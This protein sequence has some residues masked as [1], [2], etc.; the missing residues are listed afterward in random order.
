MDARRTGRVYRPLIAVLVMGL[1][2]AAC[3]GGG[4]SGGDKNR[5]IYAGLNDP[6]D[7]TIAV[8]SFLPSVATVEVGASVRWAFLGPEPHTVTFVP[9]G[10][11][12]PLPSD[13]DARAVV[14]AN[15]P[16]D[17]T[18]KVSSGL[19]GASKP[20]Q[21]KITFGKTGKF[22]YYCSIHPRM[23]ATLNVVAAGQKSD[24]KKDLVTR[25]KSERD[26]YLAEGRAGKKTYSSTQPK[27]TRNADGS[28]TWT[29]EMGF[30]T[31]HTD[32]LA[33]QPVPL[34]IKK[35]DK[36][37]F[38]NNDTGAPHTASFAGTKQIPQ[39]PE[40]AEAMNAAPGKSPQ[41]LNATGFFNTG[42]LPPNSPPGAGPPFL[43]RSFTF[44]VPNAGTYAFVCIL[45]VPSGMAGSLEA[46]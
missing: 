32:I 4:S 12:Q 9:P 20:G 45:H 6:T 36:V 5:V 37:V 27:Q 11:K 8:M 3:G 22:T 44:T 33:F 18:T 7:K 40:S 34:K 21:F 39:N 28:S 16:W 35:G 42:W 31:Q 23:S 14:P 26:R 1:L 43:A 2:L 10:A 19:I 29:V 41:T 17:A 30:S 13:A 38:V 15:G 24:T 25:G 46:T